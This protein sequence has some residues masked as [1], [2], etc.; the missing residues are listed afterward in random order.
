MAKTPQGVNQ[1]ALE[2]QTG[3][4]SLLIQQTEEYKNLSREAGIYNTTL[5]NTVSQ[6]TKLNNLIEGNKDLINKIGNQIIKNSTYTSQVFKL[7]SFI[8]NLKAKEKILGDKLSTLDNAKL[9]SLEKQTIQ[10]AKIKE[11]LTEQ[12]DQYEIAQQNLVNLV[13]KQSEQMQKRKLTSKQSAKYEKDFVKLMEVEYE[14][15]KKVNKLKSAESELS[16]KMAKTKGRENINAL[17]ITKKQ[18]EQGEEALKNLNEQKKVI[19]Q[20]NDKLKRGNFL[21][22]LANK[23]GLRG[24]GDAIKS[25]EQF[26]IKGAVALGV[27]SLIALSIKEIVGFLLKADQQI[28]DMSKQLGIS[29]DGAA[30]LR[31]HFTT[32]SQHA[33][34]LNSNLNNSSLSI[35]NLVKAQTSLNDQLGIAVEFSDKVLSDQIDLT[36]QMG[37]TEET[38]GEIQKLAFISFKTAQQTTDEISDQTVAFRK[39]TGV[40][41]DGRKVLT[42]VAKIE[43]Q[44]AVQYKNNPGLIAQAVLQ[45]KKYGITLEEAKKSASS[46]LEFESSISNELEAELLT[47]KQYNFEKARALALDGKSAEAASELLKQVGSLS[48]YQKLNIIQQDSLAKAIGMSSDELSNSLRSQQLLHS[49]SASTT[50]EYNKQLALAKQQGR[51]AD[52]MLKTKQATDGASLDATLSQL[53]AQAKFEASWERIKEAIGNIFTP[54]FLSSLQDLAKY[55]T[56]NIPTIIKGI[57]NIAHPLDAI[58]GSGSE[59]VHDSMVNPKG[60][61]V[62]STPKGNIVPDKNDSIITTTNPSGLLGGGSTDMSE[63]NAKLDK[64]IA[65]LSQGGNVY[66]DSKKVG[67]TQGLA[68]N[69]WG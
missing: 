18:R 60:R 14:L 43:G 64:L 1:E 54:A 52:F 28:T 24:A 41:L 22:E 21:R 69:S 20:A 53:S 67:T 48:D 10:Y 30:L 50:T 58:F 12:E 3:I 35:A 23:L 25:H 66:L 37:L 38:A 6:T 46:L 36:V 9:Q 56:E 65:L 19:E 49:V 17:D 39:Q 47:G 63:T 4:Q 45:A 5:L 33:S 34:L 55:I 7:E 61:V 42:E 40:M 59:T 44:L 15:Q 2:T 16:A 32:I 26:G 29:K 11:Q 51:E 31:D 8:N 27:V 62:I 68:Y 57:N 13:A